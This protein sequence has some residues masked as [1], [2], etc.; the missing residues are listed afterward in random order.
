MQGQHIVG[1]QE[2]LVISPKNGDQRN[3]SSVETK[4]LQ[5]VSKLGTPFGF[6]IG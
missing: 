1:A 2:Y 4:A 6:F 5:S 3:L